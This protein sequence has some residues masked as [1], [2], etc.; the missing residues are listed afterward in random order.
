VR[1]HISRVKGEK[2]AEVCYPATMVSLIF[3]DVPGND[4]GIIA[5]GPTVKDSSTTQ[6][7]Q[8]II[9][10]YN[11]LKDLGWDSVSLYESP[12]EDMYFSK[13]SNILVAS[14]EQA[15]MAMKQKAA[16]IGWKTEMVSMFEGEARD[17]GKSFISKAS[18][19]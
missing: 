3:S 9:N 19:L 13:V 7:A 5:S 15:V 17:L 14:P 1:K 12:K 18:R 16:E 4:L 2:L 10:K 8:K 6:D 11:V